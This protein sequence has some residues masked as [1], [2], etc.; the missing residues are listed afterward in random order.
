MSL[1]KVG[2]GGL[3]SCCLW[4][5]DTLVQ[6]ILSLQSTSSNKLKYSSIGISTKECRYDPLWNFLGMKTICIRKI[7]SMMMILKLT[8]K[9]VEHSFSTPP[10]FI[11][12]LLMIFRKIYIIYQFNFLEIRDRFISHSPIGKVHPLNMCFW[13]DLQT[14]FQEL[15][16]IWS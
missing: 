4:A 1:M 7:W 6:L 9:S 3:C 15:R 12:L 11:L 5:I 16:P 13:L 14:H 10:V 8:W 2:W